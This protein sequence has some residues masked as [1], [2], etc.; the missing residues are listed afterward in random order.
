MEKTGSRFDTQHSIVA[1]NSNH[2]D[3]SNEGGSVL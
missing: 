1:V 3:D 2:A